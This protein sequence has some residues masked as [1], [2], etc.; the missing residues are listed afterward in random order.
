MLDLKEKKRKKN[1]ERALQCR[2]FLPVWGS[3]FCTKTN[4]ALDGSNCSLLLSMWMKCP[5][6][7]SRGTK[8]LQKSKYHH[9]INCWTHSFS[10]YQT[11]KVKS[12]LTCSSPCLGD[13]RLNISRWSPMIHEWK[14]HDWLGLK[15]LDWERKLLTQSLNH[16]LIIIDQNSSYQFCF[17]LNINCKQIGKKKKKVDYNLRIFLTKPLWFHAKSLNLAFSFNKKNKKS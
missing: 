10:C 8:Y 5:T 17:H 15:G 12:Q 11:S 14:L 4:R 13:L 1:L 16:I 2:W 3:V 6:V 7:M 9:S